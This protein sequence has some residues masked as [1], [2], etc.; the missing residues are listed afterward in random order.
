MGKNS[1]EVENSGLAKKI[2]N[3]GIRLGHLGLTPQSI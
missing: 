2:L 1:R 3:T